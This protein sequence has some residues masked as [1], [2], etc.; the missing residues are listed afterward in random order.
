ML[1]A[2]YGSAA[3]VHALR[4]NLSSYSKLLSLPVGAVLPSLAGKGQ[5]ACIGC[6]IHG[7]CPGQAGTGSED[8]FFRSWFSF[9]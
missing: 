7:F 9:R 8:R 2:V 3:G 1:M 4:N 5:F 6:I